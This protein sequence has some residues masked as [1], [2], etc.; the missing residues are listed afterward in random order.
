MFES[1]LER[2]LGMIMYNLL[3]WEHPLHGNKDQKRLIFKLSYRASLILKLSNVMP[4]A[5]LGIIAEGIFFSVLNYGIETHM[6]IWLSS[7]TLDDQVRNSTVYSK[8][9]NRK[10]YIL[11]NKV[12]RCLNNS[13]FEKSTKELHLKAKSVHQRCALFFLNG[14]QNCDKEIAQ[15]QSFQTVTNE[16]P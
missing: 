13:N 2:L 8:A 5:R 4:K 12:L 7:V 9:D 14:S 16:R 1:E 11:V 3:I 10:L 15:I 6:N